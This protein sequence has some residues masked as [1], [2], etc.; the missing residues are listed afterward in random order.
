MF[1]YFEIFWVFYVNELG[2][3]IYNVIFYGKFYYWL[4]VVFYVVMWLNIDCL[5]LMK[6]MI[7]IILVFILIFIVFLFVLSGVESI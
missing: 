7:L 4:I 5:F 2:D 3:R 1:N 6:W